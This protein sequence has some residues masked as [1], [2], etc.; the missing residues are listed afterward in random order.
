MSDSS[1]KARIELEPLAASPPLAPVESPRRPAP[2]AN[3]KPIADGD[4]SHTPVPSMPLHVCPT[5]EYNLTG[6]TR[7]ICPECGEAFTLSDARG[8]GFAVG[9]PA[10][11]LHR[12]LFVQRVKTATGITLLLLSFVV[13]NWFVGGTSGLSLSGAGLFMLAVLA[14]NLLI[15]SLA[16]AWADWEWGNT[17]LVCGGIVFVFALLM[18]L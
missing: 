9:E 13:A 16:R 18:M 14:G 15:A 8:A 4:L 1:D 6:L 3:G 17:L 11:K 2:T 12:L 5:C 7:R 10:Q